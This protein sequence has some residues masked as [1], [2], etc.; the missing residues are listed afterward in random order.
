VDFISSLRV[1]LW[2][3][4][5]EGVPLLSLL[6]LYLFVVKVHALINIYPI[7]FTINT[8]LQ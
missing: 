2:V 4:V 7:P 5:S 8:E 6:S 1:L 3:Y